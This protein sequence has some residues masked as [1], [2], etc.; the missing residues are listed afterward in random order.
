MDC[1]TGRAGGMN[2][3]YCMSNIVSSSLYEGEGVVDQVETYRDDLTLLRTIY[4]S[5]LSEH[6]IWPF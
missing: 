1:R 5:A 6:E 4:I 3:Q 2:V